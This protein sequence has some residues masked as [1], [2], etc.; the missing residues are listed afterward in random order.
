MG[1][2]T[3]VSL[4]YPAFRD[5]LSDLVCKGA[6]RII[7]QGVEAELKAFLDEHAAEYDR[8]GRQAIVRNG[9]QPERE[10]LTGIGL[11]KVQMPKSRDRAGQG[12]CFR[13]ELL[14]P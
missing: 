10:V 1:N 9:Y 4:S 14:L 7:R 12:R 3:I 2:D 11:V 5:E 13:P 8:Q 6:H